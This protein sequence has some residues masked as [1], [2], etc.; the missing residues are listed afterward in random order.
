[1]S[2]LVRELR[3]NQAVNGECETKCIS[4]PGKS[5]TGSRENG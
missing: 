5:G 4:V 1:M 3:A 2:V